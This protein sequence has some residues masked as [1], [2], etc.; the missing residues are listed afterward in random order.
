MNP[1]LAK[2]HPEPFER[3]RLLLFSAV[4]PLLQAPLVAGMPEGVFYF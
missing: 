1:N 4:L 3:L 2:L